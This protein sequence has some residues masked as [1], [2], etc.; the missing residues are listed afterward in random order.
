MT[1]NYLSDCAEVLAEGF[2]M[3][4]DLS[5]NCYVDYDDFEIIINHWLDSDCDWPNDYCEGADF[6]PRDSEVD[7]FDLSMFSSQWLLCNDPNDP[8]CPM[9]N[10]Q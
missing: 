2:G 10:P 3:N 6:E 9:M 5:G 1:G 4:S 7:L 8:N